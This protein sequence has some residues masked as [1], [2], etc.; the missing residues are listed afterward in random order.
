MSCVDARELPHDAEIR[1]DV[2][3][4]GAGAAGTVLATELAAAGR[5]VCVLESGG[6]TP[7]DETQHLYDLEN[8]GYPIRENFTSRARYYGGSCNLWTGRTMRLQESDV[9]RDWPISYDTLAAYYPR[10]EKILGLPA[11]KR[12]G[13]ESHGLA[14]SEAERRLFACGPLAPTI[15]LWATHPKRFGAAYYNEFRR[16]PRVRVLLHANATTLTLNADGTAIE[17]LD[18]ITL[19][20]GRM[21]TRAR[22]YVLACGALENARLLLANRIGNDLDLVGRFYMDHPR[23]VFGCVHLAPTAQF[24][25]IHGR[26]LPDGTVQLGIGFSPETRRC[27]SL[28]NH[29]ATLEAEVTGFTN[30]QSFSCTMKALLRRGYGR[31][32]DAGRTPLGHMQG[33]IYLLTPKEIVPEAAVTLYTRLRWAMRSR[34]GGRRDVVYFCEQRPDRESR[35]TLSDARDELGMPKLRLNWRV[36]S[37]VTDGVLRLQDAIAQRF[38]E[39]GIGTLE[40]GQGEPRFTDASHHIG[41]ARM[42]SAPSTGVVD[43]DCRVHGVG[44]LFV[45]GSAVF[46]T[47]GHAN[48]TL[49]IIALALRL[50]ERLRTLDAR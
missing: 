50:A 22:H 6:L 7:E 38:R 39:A 36:A 47:E 16:S 26:P 45:A 33:M 1:T 2:C 41:T 14:M 20:G 15:S 30:P 19:H 3:I 13:A 21:R 4:V 27:E 18:A 24:P 25:M 28:P 12:V 9:A 8:V 10:A 23:A 29:Y 37:D 42:S 32:L 35:V 40:P 46:P 34:G 43:P 31:R 5:D 48:P 44:N 11:L 49:T 17:A